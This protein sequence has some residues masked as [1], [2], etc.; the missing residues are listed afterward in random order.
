MAS[1]FVV[2]MNDP[3]HYGLGTAKF[4]EVV[5]SVFII[6]GVLSG[7]NFLRTKP[8]PELKKVVTTVQ[9]TATPAKPPI[10]VTTVETTKLEPIKPIE[11]K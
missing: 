10:V 1:G 6:S 4:L 8:M 2:A 5:G 9:T 11:P 7:M 3:V